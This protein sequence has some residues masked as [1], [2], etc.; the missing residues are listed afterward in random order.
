MLI[1]NGGLFGFLNDGECVLVARFIVT[2][3][4]FTHVR[5][6]STRISRSKLAKVIVTVVFFSL[7]TSGFDSL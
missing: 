3:R 4:K 7:S 5:Y 1:Y 2:S 6:G